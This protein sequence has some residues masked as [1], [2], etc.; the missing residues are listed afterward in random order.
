MVH[1]LRALLGSLSL[2]PPPRS[3]STK[4]VLVELLF[5]LVFEG[6]RPKRRTLIGGRPN[7][8]LSN[9]QVPIIRPSLVL[10]LTLRFVRRRW[11][12]LPF[13]PKTPTLKV[14]LT[15]IGQKTALRPRHLLGCPLAT[16]SFRPTPV[17]GKAS[18]VPKTKNQQPKTKR[19]SHRSVVLEDKASDPRLQ[20]T[21]NPITTHPSSTNKPVHSRYM[22]EDRSYSNTIPLRKYESHAPGP[23]HSR[24]FPSKGQPTQPPT[25]NPQPPKR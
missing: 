25:P 19:R 17:P 8:L 18:T 16:P 9:P 14:L 12:P 3:P 23:Y 13:L 20:Q 5:S 10:F 15:G 6:T 7:W 21:E 1:L 22:S 11:N 2:N 24:P 4:V